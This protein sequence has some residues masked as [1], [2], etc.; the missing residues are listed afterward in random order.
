MAK[1]NNSTPSAK[2]IAEVNAQPTVYTF[3]FRDVPP[4]AYTDKLKLLF[5]DPDF[6]EAVEKRNR[7]VQS[8]GRMRPG[9]Q[10]MLSL[11]K[12]IQQRDRRLADL[13][14]A[15]LVQTNLR[16]EVTYDFL[17]FATLLKYYVD[18]SK[19]GMKADV[20]RLAGNLDKITFLADMLEGVLVDV[21]A[22][23]R[24]VFGDTIEFNQF[25]AVKQTLTQLRGFF[26]TSRSADADS[27][28]AQLYFDYSDSINEY[29]EKRLKTYTDRYRKLHPATPIY[30][31]G[32]MVS[33]VNQFFGTDGIFTADIVRRTESGGV[34]I[35]A[36]AV[37][38]LL[39]P[40]QL[41]QLDKAVGKQKVQD[42]LRYSF[43]VTDAI[44]SRYKKTKIPKSK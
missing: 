19:D 4:E 42:A 23:M 9:S 31:V 11:V 27:P 32:D 2:R 3:N 26:K 20:D 15:A 8:A 13:L 38:Q 30:R 14:Y 22:D 34:Y 17:S 39:T 28:E 33:A 25:D 7:L 35:D 18:Y 29:L 43:A 21:K 44:M 16:S 5:H 10:E 12:T 41:A 24:H 37:I 1:S 6:A 40:D 36:A